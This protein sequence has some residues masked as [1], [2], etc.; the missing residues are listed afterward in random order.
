MSF[1]C[2]FFDSH[3]GWHRF[4]VALA[5]Q[6][7]QVCKTQ[8]CFADEI[9]TVTMVL[10]VRRLNPF[11]AFLMHILFY[12]M[13]VMCSLKVFTNA[14]PSLE[15]DNNSHNEFKLFLWVWTVLS[16]PLNF[17]WALRIRNQ[18]YVLFLCKLSE[19]RRDIRHGSSDIEGLG[20]CI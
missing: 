17:E 13:H 12:C 3:A 4:L 7:P 2:K 14:R 18:M 9:N 6:T 5:V 20:F 16:K 8:V 15:L 11:Q 19:V 10:L 1:A